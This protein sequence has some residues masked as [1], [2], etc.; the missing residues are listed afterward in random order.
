MQNKKLIGFIGAPCSGKSTLASAVH[1][2]LK[3]NH[4]NS[5]FISETSTNY[6]AEYGLPSR[7]IDQMVIFY[8]QVLKERAFINS[9]DFIICDSCSILTY[10]YYRTMFK[11]PLSPQ[12]VAAINHIQKEILSTVNDWHKIFY[13]N[14]MQDQSLVNDGI[15]VQNQDEIMKMDSWIKSYMQ[16]EQIDYVDLSAIE[17]EKRTEYVLNLL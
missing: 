16:M 8:K 5:I 1:T 6:I 4:K 12:D 11:S 15:R 13:V 3:K 10:F 9:K 7:P 14:P 17:I 2:Q